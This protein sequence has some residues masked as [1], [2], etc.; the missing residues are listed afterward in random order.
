MSG[1]LV[2]LAVCSYFVLSSALHLGGHRLRALNSSSDPL[3]ILKPRDLVTD[4]PANDYLTLLSAPY[5]VDNP[6]P[7]DKGFVHDDSDGAGTT[8][9]VLDGGFN[10][11][12]Y[13]EELCLD[14]RRID[15]F[16]VPAS[17]RRP[18]LTQD[19][20]QAGFYY[21]PESMADTAATTA[22]RK[23]HGHGT[24]I[25]ILAAGCK[26]GVAR[27]ANLYLMKISESKMRPDG[28]AESMFNGPLAQVIALRQ[29]ASLIS[30][31]VPDSPSIPTGKAIVLMCA[32][33]W[34]IDA[35]RSQNG[36]NWDLLQEQFSL[37]MSRLEQLGVTFV[38]AAG[39]DG[40]SPNPGPQPGYAPPYLDQIMPQSFATETD[41]PITVGA[42]NNKGQLA[43]FTS[44]GRGNT[45]VSLYAQGVELRSTDLLN[46]EPDMRSG[47]SY[48]A[49]I[50]AGLAAYTLGLPSNSDLCP[51]NPS[52]AAG[53]DSVGMCLKRH[54]TESAFQRVAADNLLADDSSRYNYPIP[55]NILVVSNG[56]SETEEEEEGDEGEPFDD[57]TPCWSD[58]TRQECRFANASHT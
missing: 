1:H 41:A 32:V 40:A 21:A 34:N 42:T 49:P 20:L 6:N 44:P 18:P 26:T 39:N 37:A 30:G 11:E 24:Q 5:D 54:L 29:I 43:S 2:F 55:A 13:P 7:V 50:V 46:S 56:A 17:Y 25:A 31:S 47:T 15:Q 12:K 48:S 53:E 16:L 22:D 27:K 3:N 23:F 57:P 10:L 51:Y 4:T 33:G 9:F 35:M 14:Q 19:D 58:D 52:P 8:I 28:L 45:P 38:I 36:P